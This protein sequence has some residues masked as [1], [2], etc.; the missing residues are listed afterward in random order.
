MANPG[1]GSRRVTNS[2]SPPPREDKLE[3]LPDDDE[4]DN[5]DEEESLE[6]GE[7]AADNDDTM[8]ASW[9]SR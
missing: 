1:T 5:D 3:P 7:D 4:D 9:S 2:L 6:A 8:L